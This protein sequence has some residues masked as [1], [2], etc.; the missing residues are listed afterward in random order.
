MKTAT[1]SVKIN[2]FFKELLFVKKFSHPHTDGR[3]SQ[4]IHEAKRLV[5]I[6]GIFI[7]GDETSFNTIYNFNF[8]ILFVI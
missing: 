4:T 2:S 1:S 7:M 3:G 5:R 6:S 8:R